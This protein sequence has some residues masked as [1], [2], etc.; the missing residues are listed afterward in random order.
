MTKCS[1]ASCMGQPPHLWTA[2][3]RQLTRGSETPSRMLRRARL[4]HKH[5]VL[6]PEAA[7]HG[8][9]SFVVLILALLLLIRG[10]E[11]LGRRQGGGSWYTAR[12]NLQTGPG[13]Q[14]VNTRLPGVGFRVGATC[15]G[16]LHCCPI[17]VEDSW[18]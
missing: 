18:G 9:L 14:G 4:A 8:S 17:R 10:L 7:D 3:N 11:Y 13:Q 5:E 16:C 1:T 15:N 12:L 2:P 6:I